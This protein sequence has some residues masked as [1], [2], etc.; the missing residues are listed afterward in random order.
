MAQIRLT[1]LFGVDSLE[2]LAE[3]WPASRL[4]GPILTLDNQPGRE[5]VLDLLRYLND[6]LHFR[7]LLPGADRDGVGLMAEMHVLPTVPAIP[8]V[9]ET[10]PEC[11]FWL[12][13]TLSDA[14]G[15]GR[16]ARVFVTRRDSGTEVV[17][18]ELPVE[19]RLPLSMLQPADP[20]F[21]PP[22]EAPPSLGNQVR[23]APD[24]LEVVLEDGEPASIFVHIRVRM[25]EERDFVLEPA[26]PIS[27]G[28][29][30]FF[31]FHCLAIHD[32]SFLPSV[33][34][35]GNHEEGEM[36]LEWV[37]HRL[38]AN[39]GG[40]GFRTI[41]LDPVH[42]PFA[43]LGPPD[44][45]ET[46][47]PRFPEWVLDDLILHGWSRLPMQ[48]T[49]GIRR[50]IVE[51][52]SLD[53]AYR[54]EGAPIHLPIGDTGLKVLIEQLVWRSMPG[55]SALL[56]LAGARFEAILAFPWDEENPEAQQVGIPIS[57]TDE[58]ALQSGVVLN[59]GLDAL[60]A[61]GFTPSIWALKLGLSLVRFGEEF[62]WDER[63]QVLVDLSIA[64]SATE[65]GCFRMRSLS[66]GDF[67]T[68]WRD[69]GWNF[70]EWSLTGISFPD[71]VEMVFGP[72]DPPCCRI[73]LY[74]IGF[75]TENNGGR[76]F[77]FTGGFDLPGLGADSTAPEVG[78][79]HASLADRLPGNGIIVHRARGKIAGDPTAPSFLLDGISIMLR[80]G[81]VSILGYGLYSQRQEGDVV[82]TEIGFGAEMGLECGFFKLRLGAQYFFGEL[83]GPQGFTYHLLSAA[84]SPIPIG[85]VSLIDLRFLG[86]LNMMPA[87]GDSPLP[88]L[89]W[90]LA[91][92]PDAVSVPPTRELGRWLSEPDTKALGVGLGISPCVTDKLALDAYF[93]MFQGTKASGDGYML[94]F[95]AYVLD[96]DQY[97]GFGAFELFSDGRFGLA[98][99]VSLDLRRFIP[100]FLAEGEDQILPRTELS[101]LLYFSNRPSTIALGQLHDPDTW[102]AVTAELPKAI[103]G[104]MEGKLV[105][106]VCFQVV[107]R[108]E[109]PKGAGAAVTI[110]FGHNVGVAGLVIYAG[111]SLIAGSWRNGSQVNGVLFT[112]KAGFRV[113]VFYVFRVGLSVQVELQFLGP[114]PSFAR[115]LATFRI[116]TP[117]FMP[118]FRL[119]LGH[120]S[121]EREP[122]RQPLVGAPI[123]SVSALEIAYRQPRDTVAL[124]APRGGRVDTEEL[125]SLNELASLPN[126]QFDPEEMAKIV[127]IATDS[128]LAVDFRQA[129]ESRLTMA[130]DTPAGAGEETVDDLKIHYRLVEMSIR[131]RPLFGPDRNVFTELLPAED[132]RFEAPDGAVGEVHIDSRVR[133]FW[134][135]DR[136]VEEALDPSRLL[137]NAETPYS[138]VFEHPAADE[139]LARTGSWPCCDITLEKHLYQLGF[140][141]V[142]IGRRVPPAQLLIPSDSTLRWFGRLPVVVQLNERPD[143]HLARL[144]PTGHDDR[145]VLEMAFDRPMA[146]IDLAFVQPDG[147]RLER[148]GL[149]IRGYTEDPNDTPIHAELGQFFLSRPVRVASL[150]SVTGLR[151]ATVAFAEGLTRPAF[152]ESIR[153]IGVDDLRIQQ[154]QAARCR[155]V[156]EQLRRTGSGRFAWLPHH[157]YLIELA[158]EVGLDD[159]L[160]GSYEPQTVR[161]TAAFPH[162]WTAGPQRRPADGGRTRALY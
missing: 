146:L 107:D 52:N 120:T 67:E 147:V 92:K 105:F 100:K 10:L 51:G 24:G 101:G 141:S 60:S 131:R 116:E 132:S 17:V 73:L 7:N 127:P 71:G 70:G 26:V 31:G 160:V 39:S 149:E 43:W 106:A 18:E 34:L 134:D 133:L 143:A 4:A 62:T 150:R 98:F 128:T 49:T 15:S 74:D 85:A 104:V 41:E 55:D 11:E 47:P 22:H 76:Y 59:P 36:A 114:S 112:I 83:T 91:N 28:P 102:L 103:R 78:M 80:L 66:G 113:H 94:L 158:V 48:I 30:R 93:F 5:Q 119:R 8:L 37:R 84:V 53:E 12:R 142:S 144:V 20:S 126:P 13:P 96:R 61:L 38:I 79:G 87:L 16:P 153:G 108:P 23:N 139:V 75:V 89:S 140:D 68:T 69:L 86:T 154:E 155:E 135:A 14:G 72:N 118:D 57:L 63:F 115:F 122:E 56:L 9:F 65:L 29:C 35:T 99:G 111:F 145:L 152:L 44:D 95:G 136:Q 157:E 3:H 21:F 64:A 77:T 2:Q 110:R 82:R 109:G 90:Y 161:P 162:S 45:E 151:R 138:Y 25:T 97:A 19:I 88:L 156:A 50:R 32:L 121:G 148:A 6:T 129:V 159:T 46:L 124:T 130:L 40:Y 27:I 58:G 54:F 33:E 42:P 117:W 125:L 81:P 1:H 123:Q 137:I